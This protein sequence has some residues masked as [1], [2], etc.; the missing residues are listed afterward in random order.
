MAIPGFE[1]TGLLPPGIHQASLGDVEDT[2]VLPFTTSTRRR[3]IFDWWKIHREAVRALVTMRCQWLGGSFTTSKV[4]PGDLDLCAFIDGPEF[5]AL[6]EHTRATIGYLLQGHGVKDFW[7]CDAFK[8][9]EYPEGHPA[10]PLSL[11]AIAYWE[12]L[13][14]HTRPDAA[15]VSHP[16]GILEVS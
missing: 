5:D 8:I 9:V 13:W 12:H 6:P 10:R 15:G 2:L 16:R 7:G 1:P 3:P 4:E 11:A 14:G